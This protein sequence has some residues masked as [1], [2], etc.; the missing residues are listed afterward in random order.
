MVLQIAREGDPVQRMLFVVRGHLQSSQVLRDG[1]KSCCMLGPG[2]FTGD[3]LLS[4]CLRRPFI[5]RLPLSTSTLVT[6]ET[7]EAFG[8]EAEDVK[9][10]TQ[11]F[12]YKGMRVIFF[13]GTKG[14]RFLSLFMNDVLIM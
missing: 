3:E 5:E 12:R 9:Y 11:H 2:N 6:L 1:L 13:L 4:W 8:L 7:T 14:R 10:V